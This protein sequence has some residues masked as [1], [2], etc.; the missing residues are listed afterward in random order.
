MASP[1][2]RT[3][4]EPSWAAAREPGAMKLRL[5]IRAATLVWGAYR[6]YRRSRH[7]LRAGA[8]HALRRA[9]RRM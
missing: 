3:R 2:S 9:A 8:K 1:S 5:M 4:R 7:D 6:L